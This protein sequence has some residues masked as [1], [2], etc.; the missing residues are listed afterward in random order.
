MPTPLIGLTFMALSFGLLWLFWPGERR[1]RIWN[2]L[3]ALQSLVPLAVISGL[4]LGGTMM[5]SI[6]GH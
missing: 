6:F 2:Q 1:P 3:P 5:F 4:A